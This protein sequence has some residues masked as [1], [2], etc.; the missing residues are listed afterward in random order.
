MPSHSKTGVLCAA[1]VAVALSGCAATQ[2]FASNPE[3]Q[4][5]R[6]GTAIGA[7]GGAA[8]GALI[9]GGWKGAL[10]G[11]GVGAIAGGA[12]GNYMD[13]QEAQLRQQMAGTG[14]EVVRTGDNLTLS[15]P[16]NVTFAF[17]SSKL[18]PQFDPVLNKLA[19]TLAE[20]NKSVIQVAGHT[21]SVG[22]HAYNMKLSQERADSVASYL[23]SRGVPANRMVTVGAG[24]DYP[25]ASND[26]DAGRAQNRRVEIT[27]VPVTE[28]NLQKA[29]Q[30]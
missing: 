5:T 22:S 17:D 18:N 30:G 16:G 7:V 14:V 4:K 19:Q 8:V 2:D 10:I 6:Q 3:K 9:G 21:D 27:I 15:M 20:Y 26:T 29:K 1:A 12:V 24:P 11:A 13:K 28:E 23:A 25:I